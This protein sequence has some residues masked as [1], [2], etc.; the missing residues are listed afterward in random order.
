MRPLAGLA[1]VLGCAGAPG[2]V[3]AAG[4]PATPDLVGAAFAAPAPVGDASISKV[5]QS[6]ALRADGEA[7]EWRTTS[8]PLKITS[9]GATNLRLSVGGAARNP[10]SLAAGLGDRDFEADAYEIAVTR[11]F[12]GKGF[13]AGDLAVQLAPHA[14]VGMTQVGGSAEAGAMLTVGKRRSKDEEVARRLKDMGVRD[15]AEFGQEGR[16]YL[17]A[18]A[19]GRAVG[20]NV[21]RDADGWDRRGW[22]T[23]P[24]ALIGDAQ[25]GVG[26]RKGNIQTSFGYMHRQVKGEHRISGAESKDDSAV[27]FSLSIKPRR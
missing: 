20:L 16:W 14:G 2:M 23:D 15:G 7:V 22:S 24:A 9:K 11:E 19:S 6:N 21:T 4:A 3:L 12:A 10:N 25:V 8:V 26:W 27:A 1:M 18:A 13:E 17:F 5:L